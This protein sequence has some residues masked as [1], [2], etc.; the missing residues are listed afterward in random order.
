MQIRELSLQELDRVYDVIVQHYS[1]LDYDLF[2]D[3]IYTM[4]HQEYKMMGIFEQEALVCYAGVSICVSL[5]H[6]RHLNVYELITHISQRRKGYAHHMVDYLQDY[7]KIRQ[8]AH[9]VLYTADPLKEGGLFLEK[10]GF[11]NN[12]A[13]FIKTL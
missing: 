8:C 12:A 7:A 11:K 10:V 3:L 4:R 13:C 5:E 9:L 6:G 1:A 2:E